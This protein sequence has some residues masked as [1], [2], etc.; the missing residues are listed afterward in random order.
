MIEQYVLD[1]QEVDEVQV[2]VVGGKGA[3]LGGLSRIEG[4]RVPGGFCVTTN[5]F[6][7]IM[8]EAPLIDVPT[9]ALT[10]L[11]VSAGTIEGRARVI[12]EMA[13]AHLEAG[14]VLV[15]TFTDPSWSPLF[16]G[17]AGLVTE[18]GGLMTHGAVIAR[19]YGLPA[20]VGVEQATRLSGSACTEPRGTSRSC[21]D[22]GTGHGC[23]PGA[24]Y[25][26][27]RNRL[28]RSSMRLAAM[29]ARCL[30]GLPNRYL[31]P[32]ARFR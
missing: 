3:H 23:A 10:G 31:P 32:C 26:S 15:T 29:V 21:H 7:R 27:G 12:L 28:Q 19:E 6:R 14:D 18:V 13:E 11:P 22:L 8:A 25:E 9:G 1:L 17:I 5:A 30:S 16:V 2:A 24:D 4:I 20:V